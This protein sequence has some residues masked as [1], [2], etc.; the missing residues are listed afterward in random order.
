MKEP[1][2]TAANI[3]CQIGKGAV[4][5]EAD[6]GVGWHIALELARAGGKVIVTSSTAAQGADA[7]DRILHE[8]PRA[9]V[10]AE[11]LDLADLNSIRNFASKIVWETKLDLL[12]NHA[13]AR[14]IPT[15]QATRDGFELHL[16]MNF[17]APFTLTALLMPVLLRA[18]SPR[19]T[20]VTSAAAS[21]GLGKICFEDLQWW[22]KYSSWKAYCQSRLAGLMFALELAR[23]C[24]TDKIRLV[25]NAA[26]PGRI[27]CSVSGSRTQKLFQ[28][29]TG[30]VESA[31]SQEACHGALSVLRAATAPD[32]VAG[33]LYGP[34]RLFGLKG[35]SV[36]VS[37][38]GCARNRAD[39]QK[40]WWIAQQLTRAYFDRFE[41]A[42]R[43]IR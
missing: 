43:H 14:K 41:W 36:P 5:T 20:T 37:I 15:R 23:R 31:L 3:P 32:A 19:V 29:A 39:A 11:V 7:I 4:V 17:L 40:L 30:I 38:P 9:H 1:I 12:V 16:G 10:R 18:L 21:M 28:T 33:S 8:V 22:E 13:T 25:S 27:A 6:H 34:S 24:R 42:K 2:W 35:N 26:Y